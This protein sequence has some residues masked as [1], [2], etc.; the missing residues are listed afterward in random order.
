LINFDNV[1]TNFSAKL[2]ISW[3]PILSDQHQQSKHPQHIHSESVN[4]TKSWKYITNTNINNNS[5]RNSK[6]NNELTSANLDDLNVEIYLN[7]PVQIGCIQLKLKFSKE[8]SGPYELRLFRP[9]KTNEFNSSS[10]SVHSSIDFKYIK[11]ITILKN[12]VYF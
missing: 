7:K 10:K 12:D 8:L 11:F 9:K 4:Y 1:K 3:T 5:I 2:P 6:F